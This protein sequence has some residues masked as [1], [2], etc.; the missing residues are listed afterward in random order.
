MDT[1]DHSDL[2]D[3]IMNRPL[4]FRRLLACAVTLM[5]APF[6]ASAQFATGSLGTLS[7]GPSFLTLSA[8]GNVTGGTV[9]ASNVNPGFPQRP[10][11]NSPSLSTVG[12]WLAVTNTGSA[13][14]ALAAG[15]TAVSFLWGTPDSFNSV[16][17]NTN[18]GSQTFSATALGLTP[19]S[20]SNTA[21]YVT[22]AVSGA[23]T[24]ITSID[25]INGSN[26]AFEIANVT[27]VPEPGT[28]AMLLSGLAAV[29]FVT[30]RRARARTH[31]PS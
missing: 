9:Y 3:M 26:G 29:G 17:I 14:L 12:N 7:T 2:E 20:T 24:S 13:S 18:A 28:Y 23:A 15:K 19:L 30:R 21:S 25:F 11:N 1:R 6:S 8:G 10:T 16:R 5:V 22:F 27:A 4:P 31:A